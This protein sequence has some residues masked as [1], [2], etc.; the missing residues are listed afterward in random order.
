MP[1]REFLGLLG[2]EILDPDEG[3]SLP[4]LCLVSSVFLSS[5][6]G[7]HGILMGFCLLLRTTLATRPPP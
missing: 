6:W 3:L 2:E 4:S 1:V 5:T 7:T